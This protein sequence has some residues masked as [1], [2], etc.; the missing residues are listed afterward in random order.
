MPRDYEELRRLYVTN[1][2]L[3]RLPQFKH[4][5]SFSEAL[6]ANSPP[7]MPLQELLWYFFEL[8]PDHF[9]C[10]RRSGKVLGTWLHFVANSRAL[11]PERR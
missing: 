5:G 11:F 10:Y 8:F 1:N 9:R 3:T 2:V 6:R 7:G 4:L